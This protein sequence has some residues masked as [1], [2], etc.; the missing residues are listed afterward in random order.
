MSIKELIASFATCAK[1]RKEVLFIYTW[2]AFICLL[3]ASNGVPP[4]LETL[5]LILTITFVGYSIYF[6]ND[7]KDLKSDLKNKELGN[8]TPAGRPL[9]SGKI[10][11]SMMK[12]FIVFSAVLGLFVSFTIN[13]QVFILQLVYILLGIIYSTEPIKLKKRFLLKQPTIIAGMMIAHLSGGLTLGVVNNA[14]LFLMAINALFTMGM[15]PLAD[16]RDR[17]ADSIMGV[18]SIPVVLGPETTVRLSLSVLFA[19]GAS[20]VVGYFQLGFNMAMLI[21]GVIIISTLIYIF[22]PLLKKWDDPVYLHFVLFKRGAPLY[23]I[24]QFVI[25]LGVLPLSFF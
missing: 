22:I 1:S 19:V 10:S 21:L 11:R 15:N 24:L 16:L 9:G 13:V 5:K 14:I 8:P 23:I 7:L 2:Q 18:K 3:I 25:F 20:F 17:R 6:Y 4:L 12:K